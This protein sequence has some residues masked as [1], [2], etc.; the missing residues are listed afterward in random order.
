VVALDIVLRLALVEKKIARQWDDW[1]ED[2]GGEVEVEGDEEKRT[3]SIA[4]TEDLLQTNDKTLAEPPVAGKIPD[5]TLPAENTNGAMPTRYSKLPPIVQLLGSKRLL[6]ALWGT[7]VQGSLMT[8]FDAVLPLFVQNTFHWTSTNAGLI[9]LAV[10]IP[11]FAAPAVGYLS[12]RFGPRWLVFTG[13][14]IAVPPLVCLRFIT[15]N[16]SSQKVLLCALLAI[17]GASLAFA[18]TPLM[19]EI[20][21]VVE[22]K[23]KKNPGI[24]GSTGAYGQAYALFIMAWAAGG[25]VGPL[26]AGFVEKSSGWGTMAWSLAVLGAAGALPALTWTGGF[27]GNDNAKSG[28]ERAKKNAPRVT[29]E[30]QSAV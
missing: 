26:W 5:Q 2:E 6:A 14:L 12:D 27:I 13:F 24:Y 20:T 29:N 19:A 3:S 22:A 11:S 8:S 23:E 1:R 7:I 30:V 9:F 15:H 4:P 18:M 16:S 17:V 25:V 28:D 21:Y 10:Y